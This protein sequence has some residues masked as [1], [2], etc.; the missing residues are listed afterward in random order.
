MFNK[1]QV[2]AII[3]IMAGLTHAGAQMTS[4][5]YTF[6]GAGKA[7]NNG[8]G[9]GKAMGNTG[10]GFKS[11]YSLNNI[12]PASYSGIDSLS[13]LFEIGLF[14]K[15]TQFRTSYA[16]QEHYDGGLRYLAMGFRITRWWSA[17]L[18]I[19]PFSSVGY[20]IKTTDFIEGDLSQYTKTFTGE[21]GI[22]QFYAGNAFRI[23]KN[24]S[25]G[26]HTSY[27]FGT[28]TQNESM[29]S[30]DQL[31]AYYISKT[32]HIRNLHADFGLQYTVYSGEWNYTLGLVY[33]YKANFKTSTDYFLAYSSDTVELSEKKDDFILPAKYG[34]GLAVEKR[35]KLR[36]GVDY[37][38]RDWSSSQFTNPML[39]VR[40][41]ERFSAGI[42]YLPYKTHRDPFYMKL[43]YRLGARY[44]K[45]YMVIDDI[46]I[47][48][49]AVSIGVGIPMRSDFSTINISLEAGRNGTKA[50]GLIEE[51]YLLLHVNLS[52]RDIWFLKPK[53]D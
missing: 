46:P 42:E 10:I 38:R 16:T 47:N 50:K 5:P 19:V 13:F 37:E 22:N 14:G 9:V 21:G 11:S 51:N 32:R 15:Y 40:N 26:V 45:S 36:I 43:Y 33:G 27:L 31:K 24:L 3:M 4:S 39:S 25:L 7:E 28:I 35:K 12:N 34:I 41:S 1:I 30:G 18:G 17:S 52:L 20:T 6:F 44:E 23:F 48:L 49:M 29:S 53:Y 8:F 2:S